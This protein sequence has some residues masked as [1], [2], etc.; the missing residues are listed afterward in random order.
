MLRSVAAVLAGLVVTVVLVMVLTYLVAAWFAVPVERPLPGSYLALN[1]LG[2]ALAGMVGGATAVRLAPHTPHGH[3]F[4]LAILILLLSLPTLLAPPS[5]GQ[6][7]WYGVV[8]SVLGPVA[9]ALGGIAMTRVRE[10]TV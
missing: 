3:V 7:S 9:V 1:L 10:R 4:A 6:P 8:V 2:S 5:A